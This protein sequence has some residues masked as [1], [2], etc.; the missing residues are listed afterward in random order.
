MI[1]RPD[2]TS[3]LGSGSRRTPAIM[4][5]TNKFYVSWKTS[6]GT[7]EMTSNFAEFHRVRLISCCC[8]AIVHAP[9][10]WQGCSCTAAATREPSPWE[11]HRSGGGGRPWRRSPSPRGRTPPLTTGWRTRRSSPPRPGETN[12]ELQ[13]ACV[14]KLEL[15][16]V[17]WNIQGSAHTSEGDAV[18][19]C[20]VKLVP[21]E[22]AN[23]LP[24][25]QNDQATEC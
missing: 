18:M 12:G 13:Y 9:R 25:A 5:R 14:P 20:G 22:P 16:S 19:M 23:A 21:A 8:I 24:G 17:S 3:L 10:R 11:S 2:C 15:H 6:G 4:E 7:V 1:P